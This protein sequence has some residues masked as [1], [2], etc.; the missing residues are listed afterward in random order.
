TDR[1][2]VFT[3]DTGPSDAIA[4]LAKGADLLV[5]EVTNSVDEYKEEQIRTGRWQPMTSE[6]QAGLIRHHIEEHIVPDEVGKMAAR[7]GVKTVVLTHLP[8]S[9]NPNDDYARFAEEVKKQFS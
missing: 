9:A 4:D 2:V 3:G 6:E 7:A 8:A 5:S 1:S